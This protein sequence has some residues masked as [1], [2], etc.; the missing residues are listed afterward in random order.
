MNSALFHRFMCWYDSRWRRKNG[1]EK[2]DDLLSFS[3]EIFSGER[4]LMNDGTWVEPG[5]Y[6][7]ILHFNREC[8]SSASSNPQHYIRNALR[9]RKLLLSSFRQLAKD[10]NEHEKLVNVKVFH[11]IS[12]LPPH[13]EKLGF[14]IERLPNSALNLVRKFYFKVL[15]KTFFPHVSALDK[16]RIEP[17]AYWLTRQ[18]LIKHFSTESANNESFIEHQ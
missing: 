17:H 10:I 11:G 5:D 16:N 14:L 18:N 2:F 8:F 4:R 7:A 9:F 3:F 1:V 15:L 13:G 6:L 12:W